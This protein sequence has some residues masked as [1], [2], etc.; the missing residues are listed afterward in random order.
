MLQPTQEAC[1]REYAFSQAV[2]MD[3]LIAADPICSAS[4]VRSFEKPP[5]WLESGVPDTRI[6]R[7]R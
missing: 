7:G 1:Q 5:L 3:P 4:A 6:A 2:S